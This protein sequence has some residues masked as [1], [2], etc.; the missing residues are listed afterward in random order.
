MQITSAA[1]F[2]PD[3]V[4]PL[5]E[6][7][8]QAAAAE[9]DMEVRLPNLI[10]GAAHS[11]KLADLH[12]HAAWEHLRAAQCAREFGDTPMHRGSLED[13]AVAVR[14]A[15]ACVVFARRCEREANAIAVASGFL[16]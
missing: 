15:S 12:K 6:D 8:L 1:A 3:T 4:S 11:R 13:A 14:R 2:Q 10:R 7:G 16:R 5:D 9:W